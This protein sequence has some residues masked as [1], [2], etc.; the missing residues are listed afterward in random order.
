LRP[1]SINVGR[2][3]W[4]A[5]WVAISAAVVLP[6][7]AKQSCAE[8]AARIARDSRLGDAAARAALLEQRRPECT[9]SGEFDTALASFLRQAGRFTESDSA[10]SAGLQSRNRLRPNL[11]QVLA[12][13]R[14]SRGDVEGSYIAARKIADEYPAYPG[15]YFLLS[16]I[17]FLR[18]NFSTASAWTQKAIALQPDGLGYMVLATSL[19][20]EKKYTETVAAVD[21]A[22]RIDPNRIGNPAGVVEGVYSLILLNRRDEAR[23]LLKRHIDANPEWRRTDALVKAA[24]ELERP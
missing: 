14:L 21:G 12:A 24:S 16:E 3:R 20:Q 15:I 8:F 23:R 11:L 19:Y 18:R 22:L 6:V 4:V 7:E 1:C 17:D 9:G 10:A 5:A 13:N 2:V